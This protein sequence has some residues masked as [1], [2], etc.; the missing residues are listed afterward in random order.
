MKQSFLD[1]LAKLTEAEATKLVEADGLEAFTVEHGHA[2]A[3]VPFPG[4]VILWL[5]KDGTVNR[6]T[7]GN[8]DEVEQ[9]ETPDTKRSG[10]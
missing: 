5:A 1:S 7:A 10:T 6:A 2:L 9:E 3:A 4:L 8:P